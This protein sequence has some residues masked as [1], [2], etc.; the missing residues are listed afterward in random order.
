MEQAYSFI[1]GKRDIDRSRDMVSGSIST[2]G[3]GSGSGSGD[4]PTTTSPLLSRLLQ[5]V[6]PGGG[7]GVQVS[8]TL[9]SQWPG[10]TQASLAAT[11][12]SPAAIASMTAALQSAFPGVVVLAPVVTGFVPI[13]ATT[14]AGITGLSLALM[15]GIIVAAVV[16]GT[17]VI[18]GGV[19]GYRAVKQKEERNR[20]YDIAMASVYQEIESS[21]GLSASEKDK[22]VT[23]TPPSLLDQDHTAETLAQEVAVPLDEGPGLG[24][25]FR[26][27]RLKLVSGLSVSLGGEDGEGHSTDSHSQERDLEG[28]H[29][30]SR[31]RMNSLSSSSSDEMIAKMSPSGTTFNPPFGESPRSLAL[32]A[33]SLLQRFSPSCGARRDE[34]NPPSGE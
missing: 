6:A 23:P 30:R 13:V 33:F 10:V 34:E 1:W 32:R 31:S 5:S 29:R 22:A 7:S 2:S 21:S 14:A 8:Y 15:A 3:N 28:S 20:E 9:V 25:G 18:T 27:R 11:V 19:Y 17:A 24:L 26:R 4:I 16:G 12:Q